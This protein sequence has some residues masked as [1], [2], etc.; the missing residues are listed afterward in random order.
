MSKAEADYA[1][2]ASLEACVEIRGLD[3]LGKVSY[4]ELAH[5]SRMTMIFLIDVESRKAA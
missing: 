4:R 5:A 2:P 3:G 1:N